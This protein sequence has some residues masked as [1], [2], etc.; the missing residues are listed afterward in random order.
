MSALTEVR[1]PD[2]G[3][4]EDVGVIELLVQPGDRITL[5]YASRPLREPESGRLTR[6]STAAPEAGPLGAPV[7]VIAGLP[8]H[9]DTGER[10]NAWIAD[11]LPQPEN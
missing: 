9:L 2:I 6:T 5:Q 11:H 4:F 10:F 8:F 1:V 3:D 7:P